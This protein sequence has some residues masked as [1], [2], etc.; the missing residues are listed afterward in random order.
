MLGVRTTAERT[1]SL[2]GDE[3]PA[4]TLDAAAASHMSDTYGD[5][6]EHAVNEPVQPGSVSNNPSLTKTVSTTKLVKDLQKALIADAPLC[7]DCGIPMRRAGSCYACE[8]CSATT[9]CS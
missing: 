2:K 7:T 6:A 9:G 1:A 3:I 8:Q 5:E 4:P